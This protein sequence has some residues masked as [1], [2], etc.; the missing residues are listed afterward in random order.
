MSENGVM[1]EQ[2]I[3]P[4]AEDTLRDEARTWIYERLALLSAVIWIGG[5]ALLF[6][7]YVPFIENPYEYFTIATLVPVIPAAFPWLFY[8]YLS[9]RRARK[10]IAEHGLL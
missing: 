2:A 1:K 5:T 4:S 9:G 6:I 10:L 8:R 7:F 3:E